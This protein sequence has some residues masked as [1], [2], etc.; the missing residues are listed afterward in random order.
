MQ[1]HTGGKDHF[2][3]QALSKG[4]PLEFPGRSASRLCA[5]GTV[6]NL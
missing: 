3:Q 2:Y 6:M 4:D 5:K 1:V